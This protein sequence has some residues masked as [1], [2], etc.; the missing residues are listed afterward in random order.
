M[1]FSI[2]IPAYN[3]EENIV[4]CL[5]SLLSINYKNKEIIVVDDAS[6]DRTVEKVAYLE[7]RGIKLVRRS[8]NGGRARALNTG[9]E[10]ASGEI[11]ITTD[12]DAQV[13]KDWL[14]FYEEEFTS[15]VIAVGGSFEPLNSRNI[16]A[17]TNGMIDLVFNNLLKKKLTTNKLSGVN[18]GV[19]KDYLVSKGGYDE[20]AWWSED[21]ILSF[22][23]RGRNRIIYNPY[24]SVKTKYPSTLKGLWQRKYYWGYAMGM[25]IR[26]AS[27]L[28]PLVWMRPVY[29]GLLLIFLIISLILAIFRNNLNIYF[30]WIF[31]ILLVLPIVGLTML[32]LTQL[33]K[34]YERDYIPTLPFIGLLFLF[35]EFAYILGMC[36]GIL[37]GR[38]KLKKPTW[39]N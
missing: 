29:F 2:I 10:V 22:D 25:R 11:I 37:S 8:V 7:K 35:R 38:G 32:S 6:T 20:K 9:L 14:K 15:D 26:E 13:P 3:E 1:K 24:I 4:Q 36:N 18:S 17:A 5:E 31:I 39:R 23:I 28:S 33:I 27:I 12:A 30:L 19:R 21:S 16:I 34:N